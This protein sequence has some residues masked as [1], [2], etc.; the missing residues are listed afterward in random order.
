MPKANFSKILII[1]S[2]SETDS[3]TARNLYDWLEA[4]NQFNRWGISLEYQ[5]VESAVALIS[6][7]QYETSKIQSTGSIPIIHIEAH[8]TNTEDGIVLKDRSTV[9]WENL[10]PYLVDL[11]VATKMNLILILGL[12]SGALFTAHMVPSDRSPCWLLIGPKSDVTDL[13]LRD[14]FVEFYRV[15]FNSGNGEEALRIL[16]ESSAYGSANTFFTPTAELFFKVT[17][18]RYLAELCSVDACRDRARKIR[19]GLEGLMFPMP[20]PE[21]IALYLIANKGAFF[22]LHKEKFFMIDLY[23]ENRDR[24]GISYEQVTETGFQDNSA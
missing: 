1:S 19:K 13:H 20:H 17:Y 7:L 16:N 9:T 22:N 15:I 12:C 21:D 5:E 24:F 18:R 3:Q 4:A 2:L 8:G 10:H 11:N 6:L 23:E 14:R